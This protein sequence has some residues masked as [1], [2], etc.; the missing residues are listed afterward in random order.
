MTSRRTPFP[1][2]KVHRITPRGRTRVQLRAIASEDEGL[3]RDALDALTEGCSPERAR[4]RL[5]RV[6]REA[7]ER[8]GHNH[9][10]ASLY[11]AMATDASLAATK[12]GRG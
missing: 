1:S 6:A 7:R 10:T 8:L 5:K 4:A 9:E 11:A 3:V 2:A 12:R